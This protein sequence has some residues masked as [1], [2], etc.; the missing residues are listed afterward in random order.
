[1]NPKLPLA[2][3]ALSGILCSQLSAQDSTL[4]YSGIPMVKSST[5]LNEGIPI[6]Q[7]W[8]TYNTRRLV[9]TTTSSGKDSSYISFNY[10][11]PDTIVREVDNK[12]LVYQRNKSGLV[13]RIS[14][15]TENSKNFQEFTYD[16]NGFL[17]KKV[18][19][20]DYGSYVCRNEYIYS[21][22]YD[23]L[24]YEQRKQVMQQGGRTTEYTYQIS[25]EYY[26]D[27]VNAF[28]NNNYGE[29]YFGR[30]N[31][32]LLKSVYY[33]GPEAINS[34]ETITYDFNQQALPFRMMRK[35]STNSG[36]SYLEV[37]VYQFE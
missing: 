25:Y 5:L 35:G 18:T 1:M 8:Y 21:Y 4:H 30:S 19:R 27:K 14:D 12:Q 2:L 29:P 3:L 10:D 34:Y 26:L 9:T 11:K 20:D 22:K 15:G 33:T 17:T 6:N 36:G 31:R 32:N 24:V 28:G 16:K 13:T 7:K 37:T 23:N